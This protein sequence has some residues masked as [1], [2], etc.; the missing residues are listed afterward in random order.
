MK[1]ATIKALEEEIKRAEAAAPAPK[2]DGKALPSDAQAKAGTAPAGDLTHSSGAPAASPA[3]KTDHTLTPAEKQ[4]RDA[5][6]EL[7]DR[8]VDTAP[9]ISEAE[10][11]LMDKQIALDKELKNM[12]QGK[13]DPVYVKGENQIKLGEKKLQEL[14]KRL[15]P[16]FEKDVEFAMR[17]TQ[18]ERGAGPANNDVTMLTRRK[19]ELEQL[20]YQLRGLEIAEDNLEKAY[21]TQF[22]KLLKERQQVSGEALNFR[23]KKEELNEAKAVL[24]RIQ[25]RMIALTTERW[26]PPRIIWHEPAKV[27]NVPAELLPIPKMAAW[28]MLAFCLP[29]GLAVA[30]EFRIRRI[31]SPDELEQE[32]HLSVLGEIARLP[33]R[34]RA[35]PQLEAKR[36][37]SET[38]HIRGER[39]QS[40]DVANSLGRYARHADPG[41]YQRSQSRGQDERG[42]ATGAKPGAGHR[43][44]DLA[45]RW[46][47]AVTGHPQGFQR[48]GDRDWPRFSATSVRWPT[49]SS[50]RTIPTCK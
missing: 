33:T 22:T 27:P 3:N 28:G 47:H 41:H 1:A 32:L 40:A 25:D 4:M 48:R 29:F 17:S 8:A 50:A 45:N 6:N 30:W 34:I 42:L 18:G 31:G 49:R 11:L 13:K 5:L 37:G 24:G 26:A 14:K 35:T 16:R 10:N 19:E 39:Q 43:K 36:I 15:R 20:R 44:G 2:A 21:S 38:A 23:F 9:A 12:V 7:V 46:R